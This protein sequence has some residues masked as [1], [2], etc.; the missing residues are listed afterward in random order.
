M[1]AVESPPDEKRKSPRYLTDAE[2]MTII[3][4]CASGAHK[5]QL[6]QRFGVRPETISRLLRIVKSVKDPANPLATG[7]YK[8]T[9]RLKA[10]AAV[11][12]GL[13]CADDAYKRANVGC[14]VL[15]GIG[16]FNVPGANTVNIALVQRTPAEWK[17]E[18]LSIEPTTTDGIEKA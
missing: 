5:G 18:F 12:D 6:A 4:A 13:D 2:R 16:E 17:A 14:R 3:A 7:Q 9:L 10:T 15:E 1:S 8:E 11:V